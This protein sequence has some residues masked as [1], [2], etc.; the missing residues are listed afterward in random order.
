LLRLGLVTGAAAWV[1]KHGLSQ[2]A[3]GVAYGAQPS[4]SPPTRAF[5]E[6]LT[7]PR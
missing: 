6:P 1:F 2:W 7:L 5:I 3:S 4:T